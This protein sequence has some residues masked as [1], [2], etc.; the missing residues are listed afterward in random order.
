[1]VRDSVA[2][3]RIMRVLY[4]NGPGV[5]GM[6]RKSLLVILLTA[7]TAVRAAELPSVASINLCTDQLLLSVAD[8]GQIVTLSWL[9]ADPVESMLADAARAF[10]LN[11]GSAEEILRFGPD[12]VIGGE[13]TSAFTRKLLT[14][15]GLSVVTISPA[16]GIGDIER[17]LR[18]IAMAIGR[19]TRARELVAEMHVRIGNIRKMR[20]GPAVRGIVVRPGGFTV[21]AGT[22]ADELLQLAGI[23][24][25][26][27]R[28]GLDAW[29][30]LSVES[31][32]RSSPDLLIFTGFRADTPSLANEILAH[33]VLGRL[34]PRTDAT[35]I[36]ATY[37]SCGTPESLHSAESLATATRKRL[38]AAVTAPDP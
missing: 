37:W 20:H 2:A 25:I 26:A 16:N 10:P 19:E 29:G 7:A 34:S 15:L 23:E 13:F 18:T 5:A 36:D 24:N 21:G 9:S 14:D 3:T 12:V 31:L 32:L 6:C 17:N 1:M 8:P 38:T 33:P 35:S 11:Y 28:Q 30:S 27:A 4:T 22:L